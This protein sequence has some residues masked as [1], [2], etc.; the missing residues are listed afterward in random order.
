M[1]GG[2]D[3]SIER[4]QNFLGVLKT[5]LQGMTEKETELQTFSGEVKE[6]DG[7]ADQTL[8][9]AIATLAEQE[10]ELEASQTETEQKL[11]ALAQAAHEMAQREAAVDAEVEKDMNE[12]AATMAGDIA[13]LQQDYEELTHEGFE[14]LQ[15]VLSTVE[16]DLDGAQASL[17]QDFNTLDGA[18]QQLETE[19]E[20]ET[21]ETAAAVEGEAT[22]LDQHV[23]TFS[24][25]AAEAVQ[26][27]AQ[28][29]PDA[30]GQAC[31]DAATPVEQTYT[32]FAQTADTEGEELLKAIETES[33]EAETQ[34]DQDREKVATEERQAEDARHDELEEELRE[35]ESVADQGA[36]DIAGMSD[37]LFP[38][39]GF[40][41]GI[42][43]Q[44]DELLKAMGQ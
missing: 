7:T 6:L 8:Q 32:T 21:T 17:A 24:T 23:Q 16:R 35:T 19:V 28:E 30:I 4:L 41:E 42:A 2:Y 37:S 34:I 39:L 43:G 27:W 29:L 31:S 3:D 9:H 15:G 40:A 10:R 11:S 20:T 38:D 12:S 1:T 18:V 25:A 14:A 22:A 33:K 36:S 44:V 13:D 26:V 5:T